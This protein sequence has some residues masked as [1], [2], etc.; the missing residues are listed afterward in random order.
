M[1]SVKAAIADFVLTMMWVFCSAT[2]GVFTYLIASAFGIVQPMTSL[3]ITTFLLFVLFFVFGIVGDALG[4]AA[5]NPA[6]TAAFYAA[7][8][9]K[10]SLFTVATRFPAQAA[11]AVAGALAILE[12]V[13][14]QFKHMLGGPSLKVDLHNGAIAEG[15]LTFVMTF[16]VFMI[17]LKGPK[18]A[19]LK[20]WLLAMSTV[21]MVVAGSKYTGPSMNPANAFG[22]A[23]INNMHNTWEQLY[24]Y[25]I[26]PFIGA[27]MAAWTFRAVFP[28]PVKPK[29]KQKK[30]RN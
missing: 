20:N 25:W 24:V 19:V 21:T 16:L 12:V 14:T 7:G 28:A 5:F 30:K 22:W 27:I 11:G 15:I 13:P 23:Y 4:G 2:L 10:D 29:L 3:F 8:V 18:N 26:C 1:G 9:G 6:G 17:V